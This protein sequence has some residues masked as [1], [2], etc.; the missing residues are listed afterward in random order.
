MVRQPVDDF[1]LFVG[2]EFTEDLCCFSSGK[3]A[4]KNDGLKW[5]AML[6]EVGNIGNIQFCELRFKG[7]PRPLFYEPLE[8]DLG[9]CHHTLLSTLPER[10]VF[11]YRSKVLH[12]LYFRESSSI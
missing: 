5:I 8:I 7:S 4:E 3:K 2:M 11:T 6:N 9:I 1:N 12:L 10:R